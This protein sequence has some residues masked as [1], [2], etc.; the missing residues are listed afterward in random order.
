MCK[1]KSRLLHTQPQN[2]EGRQKIKN[3]EVKGS[4]Q[5]EEIKWMIRISSPKISDEEPRHTKM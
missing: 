4:N 3:N 5:R 1:I 2:S